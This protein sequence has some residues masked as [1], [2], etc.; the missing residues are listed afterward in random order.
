[1]EMCLE[2]SISQAFDRNKCTIAEV[3]EALL[4]IGSNVLINMTLVLFTN[5]CL[6]VNNKIVFH[7][8]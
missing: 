8:N 5:P 7:G 6:C 1:M 3:N 4:M 2:V